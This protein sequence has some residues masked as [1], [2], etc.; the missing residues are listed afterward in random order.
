MGTFNYTYIEKTQLA[1]KDKK[2]IFQKYNNPAMTLGYTIMAAILF[3]S[4]VGYQIDV[5][6]KTKYWT[7][8]GVF[9]GFL[10]SGYEVWKLVKNE[11]EKEEAAKRMKKEDM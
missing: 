4:F 10:Y 6:F 5:R 11:N 7:F 3:F 1:E 2:L 8:V 9:A